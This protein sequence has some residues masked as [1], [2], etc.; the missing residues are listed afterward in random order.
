MFIPSFLA[1]LIL[2]ALLA[3]CGYRSFKAIESVETNDDTQWLTF[4]FVWS[5]VTMAKSVT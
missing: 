4:W 5:L 1:P 3:L 2:N